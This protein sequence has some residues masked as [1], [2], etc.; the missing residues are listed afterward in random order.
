MLA[1]TMNGFQTVLK[2][3]E[4]PKILCSRSFMKTV[5]SLKFLTVLELLVL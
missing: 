1:L 2:V 3:E 5:D 4:P